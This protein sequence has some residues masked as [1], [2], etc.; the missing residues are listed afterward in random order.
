MLL[1]SGS[2]YDQAG[3][4]P[5]L[6]Q[7]PDSGLSCLFGLQGLV[8]EAV[9]EASEEQLMLEKLCHIIHSFSLGLG[10]GGTG[11][12]DSSQGGRLMPVSL[13][14]RLFV[15]GCDSH[16]WSCRASGRGRRS[17]RMSFGQ[18]IKA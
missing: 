1:F 13:K 18:S 7:T 15:P 8:A 4:P 10:L 2:A 6:V 3:W 11:Q 14:C 5:I 16:L 17:S 12:F 9:T